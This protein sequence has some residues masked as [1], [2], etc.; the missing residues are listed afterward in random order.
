MRPSIILCWLLVAGCAAEH[1]AVAPPAAALAHPAASDTPTDRL[2]VKSARLEI[3]RS[4]PEVGAQAAMDLAKQLGGWVQHASS[5]QVTAMVPADKL[6]AYLAELAKLGEVASKNVGAEDVT[7]EY[8]DLNIR[9]DNLRK[10]RER[11][12]DLL[13]RSANVTEATG[14]EKELE[15]VTLEIERLE[16]RI[17]FLGQGVHFSSVDAAFSRPLRPGPVGWVFYGL[18]KGVKWMLVWD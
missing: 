4:D 2:L 8:L 13:A 11:Y 6:D 10:E 15:R 18:F 17:K 3:E 12:L 7:E 9:L 5:V 14:V 1:E 16:G